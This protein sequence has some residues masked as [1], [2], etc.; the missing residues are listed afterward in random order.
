MALL[1]VKHTPHD[2]SWKSAIFG[3]NF[4]A[5]P[6]VKIGTRVN[7]SANEWIEYPD[8][9]L[10]SLVLRKQNRPVEKR[11]DLK[12]EINYFDLQNSLVSNTA[13]PTCRNSS[14]KQLDLDWAL[15]YSR[16]DIFFQKRSITKT[17]LCIGALIGGL[18]GLISHFNAL[19]SEI[20]LGNL[21]GG[22]I[23]SKAYATWP[24]LKICH[25]W[26]EFWS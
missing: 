18:Q 8:V 9:F 13:K 2:H 4:G 26:L 1:G 10:W 14:K 20:I 16:P 25:F 22:S 24:F 6:R 23:G 17:R 15:N 19:F 5:N 12:I 3:L 11:F 21:I 7:Y